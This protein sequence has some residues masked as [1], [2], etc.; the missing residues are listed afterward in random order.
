VRLPFVILRAAI[1][2]A[3]VMSIALRYVRRDHPF[4]TFG[5]A[6][7]VTAVRAALASLMFG[8]I[9]EPAGP[10]VAWTAALLG[11][12]ATVLDGVDGLFARRTGMSSAFGARFD[13]EVDAIIVLALSILVW[14]F[15]KAGVW[16]IASG[17]M[18]Y[19]FIGAGWLWP[20]LAAPLA[21]TYRAKAICVVQIVALLVAIL[22]FVPR[23]IS[24][25]TVAGAL[26]LLV[27][28]F[29]ADGVRLWRTR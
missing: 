20:W 14:A 26:A 5:P 12:A 29:L 22:P 19:A 15:D 21:P 28:S 3:A 23:V 4:P 24:S 2:F 16:A 8:L 18:R 13:M 11:V 27:Y 9:G 25:A 10:A 17:L 7:V 6:N 1:V